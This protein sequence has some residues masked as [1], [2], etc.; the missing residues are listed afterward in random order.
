MPVVIVRVADSATDALGRIGPG[1]R[2]A[3]VKALGPLAAAMTQ[4]VRGRAVAH[5]H[6]LGKK[7][8]LYLASI[9]GGVSDKGARLSGYVRSGSPLAHLL[10][11]GAT[12]PPHDILARAGK[13]LAFL[14]GAETV[15]RRLVHHPGA[16]IPAY[17][18]FGPAMAANKAHIEATLTKAVA[19]ATEGSL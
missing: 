9:H 8:G 18:A 12:T 15:F 11:Y 1:A 3:L 10:E 17:P 19:D 14:A 2:A 13:V 16:S 7:P 5:I 4:D 6:T